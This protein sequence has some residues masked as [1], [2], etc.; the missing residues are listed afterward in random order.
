MMWRTIAA[1]LLLGVLGTLIFAYSL[2]KPAEPVQVQ[3]TFPTANALTFLAIGDQGVG[4]LRQWQVAEAMER[5]AATTEVTGVFL[6][7]DNF[8][9]H[10]VTSS[11]DLQWRY[12]FENVYTGALSATPFFATLGNHDYF[13]SSIAQIEYDLEDQGS[14]RWQ[15]PARDYVKSFGGDRWQS[16]VR[17]AF[18]DTGLYVRN[19]ED[20]TRVLDQLLAQASPATWTLVVTHTPLTSSNEFSHQPHARELWRPVLQ[21]HRVDAILAGHDHNMQLLEEPGWPTSVIV[22]VGGKSGQEVGSEAASNLKFYSAERGF[23][24]V[25]IDRKTLRIRYVSTL[26]ETLFEHQLAR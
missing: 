3:T 25:D 8:Y 20:V 18:I 10:G 6:L 9:S 15:F 7:G 11:E 22:G 12:K 19:P 23:S 26:G 4:N 17:V 13:G 2:I 21:K 5:H 24:V 14:T 1:A 16:L